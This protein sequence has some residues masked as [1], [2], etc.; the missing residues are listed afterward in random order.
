MKLIYQ[1]MLRENGFNYS[2]RAGR[3]INKKYPDVTFRS[4]GHGILAERKAVLLN[5][6]DIFTFLRGLQ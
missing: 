6:D 1:Q 5:G 3:W 2:R 4:K